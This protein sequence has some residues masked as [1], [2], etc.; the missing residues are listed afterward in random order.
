M[1]S[2]LKP[3][4]I[5]FGAAG[6]WQPPFAGQE[7]AV[8]D[9]SDAGSGTGPVWPWTAVAV[10]ARLGQAGRYLTASGALP[11]GV[12]ELWMRRIW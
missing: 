11:S 6:G 3:K 4:A 8:W 5:G 9:R 1:S 2:R 12:A 7:V 10:T